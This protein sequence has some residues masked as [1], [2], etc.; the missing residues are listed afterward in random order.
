MPPDA[1]SLRILFLFGNPIIRLRPNIERH[2]CKATVLATYEMLCL[3]RCRT[4]CWEDGYCATSDTYRVSD[5]PKY[6]LCHW[7]EHHPHTR[8]VS[9]FNTSH[10]WLCPDF[11]CEA[12]FSSREDLVKHVQKCSYAG[13]PDQQYWCNAHEKFET[14]TSASPYTKLCHLDHHL[15][16]ESHQHDL[17]G[18]E[19]L[20][21]KLHQNWPRRS[22]GSH[23]HNLV[24]ASDGSY[25]TCS[26]CSYLSFVVG[27]SLREVAI[28]LMDYGRTFDRFCF[29][30][31]PH[32]KNLGYL[33]QREVDRIANS[34][35]DITQLMERCEGV[36]RNYTTQKF[37]SFLMDSTLSPSRKLRCPKSPEWPLN[38]IRLPGCP[39]TRCKDITFSSSEILNHFLA[40]LEWQ[41]LSHRFT[42]MFCPRPRLEDYRPWLEDC[43][44]LLQDPEVKT[45]LACLEQRWRIYQSIFESMEKLQGEVKCLQRECRG[46]SQIELSLCHIE[47]EFE[48]LKERVD[49]ELQNEQQAN[50]PGRRTMQEFRRLERTW[51]IKRPEIE[52]NLKLAK[53]KRVKAT[54]QRILGT[55]EA[56]SS[57]RPK[58]EQW[59]SLRSLRSAWNDIHRHIL[60]I[61]SKGSRDSH[62]F[63]QKAA[64]RRLR[65][66]C[67]NSSS[68]FHTGIL[69]LR[70]ILRGQVPLTLK[71]VLA[72]VC[73]SYIMSEVLQSKGK[74]ARPAD[75]FHGFPK[76][77]QA[78]R[79]QSE[80]EAFDEVISL[81]WTEVSIPSSL[82]PHQ[83]DA[84]NM[85]NF[86]EFPWLN[87]A[88]FH[89][90][91]M[92]Q[93][94]QHSEAEMKAG[95]DYPL[96]DF[97][98]NGQILGFPPLVDPP[99]GSFGRSPPP[100]SWLQYF[101]EP[102][103]NLLQQTQ[104]S[105]EFRL[106]DFLNLP[107][108][109]SPVGHD[110]TSLMA[111]ESAPD[112][113]AS[114]MNVSGNMETTEKITE[115]HEMVEATEERPSIADAQ[116]ALLAAP[117]QYS[118]STFALLMTLCA[119]TIFQVALVFLKCKKPPLFI[120]FSVL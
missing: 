108:P 16:E 64:I 90:S 7:I 81:I 103:K 48:R 105:E 27:A 13:T 109:G 49:R 95:I 35:L 87:L 84:V 21:Y 107:D 74:M 11:Y 22:L 120:S 68:F 91:S 98:N 71:E 119:T 40:H 106:S 19:T 69:T 114:I 42:F 6:L 72:F 97:T 113:T 59:D 54:V 45:Q 12:Q 60:S 80:R 67:K 56:C 104:A 10:V 57:K 9:E 76:W 79:D 52:A 78:I 51:Q 62:Q 41:S 37:V 117:N 20:Y 30:E 8:V 61:S 32:F 33:D 34:D 31:D 70:D 38:W 5:C 46:Q 75:F 15:Q 102:V 18:W 94:S 2:A 89:D 24:P 53:A 43:S 58:D 101:Q 65:Q 85:N 47:G 99:G 55:P 82:A 112:P 25:F 73:L 14:D 44:Y 4:A 29:P 39:E 96:P 23:R 88:D 86:A 115:V 77:R 116:E 100:E 3:T 83:Q 111:T 50:M 118:P 28:H 66:Q 36:R 93:T 63:K 26:T 17:E 92:A 1:Y 110:L